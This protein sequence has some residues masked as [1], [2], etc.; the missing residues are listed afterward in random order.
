MSIDR[1]LQAEQQNLDDI[2]TIPH[3]NALVPLLDTLYECSFGLVPSSGSLYHGR[4]LLVCHKSLLSAAAL[5]ARLQPENAA[6]VTRRSIE[7]ALLAS[8]IRYNSANV[9]EWQA[10]EQRTAR[11]NAR[12]EGDRP[13]PLKPKIAYPK[14][15][16]KVERL[17]AQLGMI[18][19]AFVHLT[20]ESMM[21]L[22]WRTKDDGP[23]VAT[24]YLSYFTTN[25]NLIERELIFLASVH[26]TSLD[27]FDECYKGA[28]RANPEWNRLRNEVEKRGYALSRQ[29]EPHGKDRGNT[30]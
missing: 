13:K 4:L 19:D 17:L 29:W 14:G 20:P 24:V 28:F 26:A 16:E 1:Y 5:I 30:R 7:A 8:A 21:N 10:F 3:F 22:S 11:W 15:D 9:K 25:R 23:H 12:A 27:I 18:S 6:P 2:R